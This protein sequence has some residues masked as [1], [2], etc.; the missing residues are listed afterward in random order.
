M[1]KADSP[2]ERKSDSFSRTLDRQL[3]RQH[4]AKKAAETQTGDKTSAPPKDTPPQTEAAPDASTKKQTASTQ[5]SAAT[6]APAKEDKPADGSTPDPQFTANPA[7]V[8]TPETTTFKAGSLTLAATKQPALNA[9][10]ATPSGDGASSQ[11]ALKEEAAAA[12]AA[13]AAGKPADQK[14]TAPAQTSDQFNKD[15]AALNAPPASKLIADEANTQLAKQADAATADGA[16]VDKKSGGLLQKAL[17]A[18]SNLQNPAQ[19]GLANTPQNPM[20]STAAPLA[21]NSDG[22]PADISQS[23]DQLNITPQNAHNVSVKFGTAIQTN[24]SAQTAI[25]SLAVQIAKQADL[26]VNRFQI[27]MDPPE[28]GRIDV[29]LEIGKN[30]HLTANLA[31]E[32]PETLDML[33][34][35]ARALERALAGTGLN[36]DS[37]SLNFSLK[38]Q[39][40]NQFAGFQ[41]DT[42]GRSSGPRSSSGEGDHNSPVTQTIAAYRGLISNTA[43]DI[44]I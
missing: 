14:P 5:D 12:A 9:A 3:D 2:P 42:D 1:K 7:L 19:N 18:V 43:V 21:A 38:D 13:A 10:P 26:G 6:D 28:L 23:L 31:V 17:T 35:D 24:Q 36:T 32:R 8:P 15:L 27:R 34:R 44:R 37:N 33:L 20:A 4:P 39:S 30:G 29:K 40:A 25:N 11:A 16:K 22:T 41:Q